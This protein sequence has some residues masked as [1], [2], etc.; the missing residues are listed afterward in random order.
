M[1]AAVSNGSLD[2][3]NALQILNTARGSLPKEYG[4]EFNKGVDSVYGVI[5][6]K[7]KASF[8]KD[9]QQYSSKT[10]ANPAM[11]AYQDGKIDSYLAG[12]A[13][14]MGFIPTVQNPTNMS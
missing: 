14:N 6:G 9:V 1:A 3:S 4:D 12:Q 7:V 11:A 5:S 2:P 8:Y 10:N 13:V